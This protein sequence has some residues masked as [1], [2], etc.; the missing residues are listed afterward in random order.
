MTVCDLGDK[1]CKPCEGGVPVL[2]LEVCEKYLLDLPQ[3]KM[4]DDH[5]FISR[6]FVFKNFLKA[7]SLSNAIGWL[8]EH[9]GHHP[10]ML[11][12]W[13]YCEVKFTTHAI[14]GL[15]ENDFI[16]ATKIDRL[17]SS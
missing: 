10:D 13:G 2:S 1:N 4:S 9:E 3:W 11:L 17:F 6:R 12:G 15:S 8:A 7:L 16:C 5:Q 14:S